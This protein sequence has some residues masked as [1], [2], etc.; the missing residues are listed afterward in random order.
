MLKGDLS[1]ATLE[2]ALNVPGGT[3]SS[4]TKDNSGNQLTGC[5]QSY[6]IGTEIAN[7]GSVCYQPA[8]VDQKNVPITGGQ[9]TNIDPGIATYIKLFPQANTTPHAV[10]KL[11]ELSNGV[12]YAKN[13]MAT[14]NGYQIHG[15]VDENFSLQ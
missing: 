10:S 5:P 9:L 15:R 3:F 2:K 1:Y 6:S 14:H 4:T 7:L 11:N 13:V 8:G 12:N